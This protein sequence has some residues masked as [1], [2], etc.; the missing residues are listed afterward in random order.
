MRAARNAEVQKR[1]DAVLAALR[2]QSGSW[3]NEDNLQDKLKEDAFVYSAQHIS[4][5]RSFDT[6]SG[7]GGSALSWLEKLQ[8]MKPVGFKE[9]AAPTVSKSSAHEDDDKDKKDQ[10]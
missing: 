8:Q 5:R 3:I 1:R 2:D 6:A 9:P 4:F 7:G 10:Q